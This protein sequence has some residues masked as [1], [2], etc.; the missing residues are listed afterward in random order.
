M[1]WRYFAWRNKLHETLRSATLIATK[2][3][4]RYVEEAV[5]CNLITKLNFCDRIYREREIQER[6]EEKAA[7]LEERLEDVMRQGQKELQETKTKHRKEL[8]KV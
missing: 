5:S 2:L 4:A 1:L 8:V 7:E 6:R 3:V